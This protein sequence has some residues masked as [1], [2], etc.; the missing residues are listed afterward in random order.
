MDSNHKMPVMLNVDVF[1]VAF[2]FIL[3]WPLLLTRINLNPSMD[4][5]LYEGDM[6]T[7]LHAL[8]AG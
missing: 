5:I 6:I 2:A 8:A 1:F 3:Q 4:I 7:G